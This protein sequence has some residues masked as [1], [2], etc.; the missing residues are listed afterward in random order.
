MIACST[1]VPEGGFAAADGRW[2]FAGTLT[3]ADAAAVFEASRELPLPSAGVVDLAGLEHADSSAL[4]VMMALSRRAAVNGARLK[5]T[6]IP[7]GLRALA[8]VYGVDDLLAG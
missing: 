1:A 2:T 4:A 8:Y 7:P 6:S 5:F 3:F